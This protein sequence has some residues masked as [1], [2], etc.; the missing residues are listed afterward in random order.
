MSLTE[1]TI[2]K[3]KPPKASRREVYDR[4]VPGFGIR[5]TDKG[6]KSFIYVFTSKARHKRVRLTIGR[7]GEISL[8]TAR[9]KARELRACVRSG[10]EPADQEAA[11]KAAQAHRFRDVLDLYAKRA[12]VGMRSGTET[13]KLLNRELLP[14][15]ADRPI[16]ATTRADVLERVEAKV[17]AGNPEAARRL[18]ESTRRL[19]N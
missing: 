2:R 3:L 4:M 9:E 16:T 18:F 13:R 5:I 1:L 10:Q 17:D 11:H 8:E 12:L 7:V 6:A 19:F 15:W 14:F